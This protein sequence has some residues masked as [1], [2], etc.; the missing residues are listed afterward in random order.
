ME[1]FQDKSPKESKWL[2]CK[3]VQA[4]LKKIEEKHSSIKNLN[5][6]DWNCNSIVSFNTLKEF[7]PNTLNCC[8]ILSDV[9]K[10]PML[11]FQLKSVPNSNT[12]VLSNVYRYNTGLDQ[13]VY[14]L[15][16]LLPSICLELGVDNLIYS[17]LNDV[18][19]RLFNDLVNIRTFN[20]LKLI[21]I[22]EQEN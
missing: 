3:S 9:G 10:R 8:F 2:K 17:S 21:N 18:T 11:S 1:V 6:L 20:N 19:I 22:H 13:T 16:L 4:A 15:D 14:I 12:L 7:N 5:V